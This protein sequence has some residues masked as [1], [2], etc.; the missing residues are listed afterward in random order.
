MS[1]TCS[2]EFST[3]FALASEGCFTWNI[4]GSGLHALAMFHVKHLPTGTPQPS[5]AE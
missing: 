5:S 3:G 1:K 4:A 2:R